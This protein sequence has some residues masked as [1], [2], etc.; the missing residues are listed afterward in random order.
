MATIAEALPLTHFK[1]ETGVMSWLRTVDHKRIGIMYSVTA[2]FFFLVGGIMALIMRVQLAQSNLKV[3]SP[4]LYNQL[5]TMHGTTMIFLFVIP[6]TVGLGN[7]LVPLMIG[8]RDMAFPRL[9]AL[10]YWLFL[11]G[12]I[13]MNSGFVTGEAASA[14]WTGYAPLSEARYT[15]APGMDLWIVGLLL[16]GTSSLMGAVNFLVT[17]WRLRAPGMIVN[18]MPLFVWATVITSIMVLF[19]TP[20]LTVALITLFLDRQF[21]TGF[22]AIE[23]GGDPLL[24]QHLFWFYSHPAVYI[25]ILP[26]MGVISEVLPVFSRKPIFGYGF[27][28]WSSVA[29][30]FLGFLVWAHHMFATGISRGVNTFFMIASMIIAVPTGVKIFN[31]IATIWG[32]SLNLKTPFYFAVGFLSMF[33]IGGITGVM[34]A[35]VPFD[36]QVHD[37]YFVVAHLHYVLFGGSVFGI[38]AGLYYW[39]PKMYGRML[40]ERLGKLHFWL[41]LIGFNLTFFPMHLLGLL[42]MPRRIYTY[43]GN[44]SWDLWNLVATIGAYLI[45]FSIFIFMINFVISITLKRGAVAGAD[46]WEGHTLEWTISS[47]PPVYNFAA[48]PTVHSRRPL[49]DRRH[50]RVSAETELGYE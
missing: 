19:A 34:V 41:M 22:F 20:M 17:V 33:I 40:N 37:T 14:G 6:I 11:F 24:W 3:L 13:V 31:W 4:D 36:W 49:W 1:E 9:N 25:M 5:F 45:A 44:L 10:G 28:A 39:L 18:R 43:D 42:G 23:R 27:V 26:A 12:G 32:G 48:I 7:Y 47:P 2:F 16:A 30:G 50:P 46:P 29:I 35:V 21:G 38:F 8:A 15:A